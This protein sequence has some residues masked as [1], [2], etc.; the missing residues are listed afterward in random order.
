MTEQERDELFKQAE[1]AR[2]NGDYEAAQPVY[3][4]IVAEFPSHPE[5]HT[6][7]GHCLLNTGMFDEALEQ[8]K[9][10]VEMCPA[11]VRCLLTY[12]KALCMMGL[13]D[14]AK[15]Y[16]LRV[17]DIDPDNEDAADQMTYFPS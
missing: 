8:Y 4:R 16:F 13:L 2:I 12:G 10:V 11:N 1:D 9:L 7:L 5:A 14:E 3:E 15:E 17:L 6:G